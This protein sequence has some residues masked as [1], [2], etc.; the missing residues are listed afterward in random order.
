MT[1]PSTNISMITHIR[2]G[3][4]QDT[5]G[6]AS[7]NSAKYRDGAMKGAGNVAMTDFANRAWAQGRT[8]KRTQDG[9]S[10]LRSGVICHKAYQRQ[11]QISRH[12]PPNGCA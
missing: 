1:V 10:T 12:Q 11:Q 4:M 3:F 7:L 8:I 5:G 2:N 9:D 6:N